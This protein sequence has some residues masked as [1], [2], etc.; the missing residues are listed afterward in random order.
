MLFGVGPV[1]GVATA[2]LDAFFV[3]TVAP[4]NDHVVWDFEADCSSYGGDPDNDCYC[5]TTDPTVLVRDNCPGVS[6]PSQADSDGDGLG[7]ACDNCP[8]AANATQ[9][10]S[11]GDGVGDACDN[12]PAIANPLQE[13]DDGDEFGNVCD[14]CPN[15]RFNDADGDGICGDVD[16]CPNEPNPGQEDL[17]GDGF[18]DACDRGDIYTYAG[19]PESH[20]FC[21]TCGDGGPALSATLSEPM[22]IAFDNAG[23]LYIADSANDRIRMVD[24]SGNVSTIAG[25]GDGNVHATDNGDGGLATQAVLPNPLKIAIDPSSTYLYVSDASNRVRRVSLIAP[26]TIDT[27][28]GTGVSGYSGDGGL[29]KSAKLNNPAGLAVTSDTLYIADYGNLCIRAVDLVTNKKIRTI[30]GNT[31]DAPGGDGGNAL[32]APV[33]FPTDLFLAGS[34]L[35]VSDNADNSNRVRVIDLDTNQIDAFAGAIA[36]GCAPPFGDNGPALTAH[37][38]FPGG[39][40]GDAAG[41]VYIADTDGNRIRKVTT[42]GKIHTIA[43]SDNDGFAGDGGPATA[44]A[45][46]LPAAVAVR[47]DG[48]IYVVDTENGRIR[49]IAYCGNGIVESGEQCDDANLADGDGCSATCRIEAIPPVPQPVAAGGT[50]STPLAAAPTASRPVGTAVT[51]P[52]AQDITIGVSAGPPTLPAGFA[53]FGVTIDINALPTVATTPLE[54]AFTFDVSLVPFAQPDT[55]LGLLKIFRD[56]VPIDDPCVPANEANPDPCVKSQTRIAGNDAEIRILSTHAS[57]W[58]AGLPVCGNGQLDGA[59]ACDDGNRIGGD[60]CS[61]TCT[62]ESCF[63]CSGG[64]AGSCSALPDS[65][66]DGVCDAQD[67]CANPSGDFKAA[68]KPKLSLVK[69]NTD[70]LPG[71]DKLTLQGNFDLPTG[72]TFAGI[73]PLTNGVRVLLRNR[74]GGTELDVTLPGGVY[75]GLGTRGWKTNATRSN[76]QYVDKTT[77]GTLASMYGGINQFQVLD[78]SKKVPHEVMVKVRGQSGTYPVVGNDSPVNATVVLGNASAG[79][80][81]LCGE[82][83][84]A[85]A[86]CNF[87]RKGDALTCK[88]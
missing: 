16:N 34:K 4:L 63:T 28:A 41:N 49:R 48:S 25:N 14:A 26:K 87:N 52:V 61:A 6:N 88:P 67:V 56:G 65:D 64:G 69:I 81:G 23:N 5:D 20:G 18:G 60:G 73:T 17:D 36:T 59:E 77:D 84:F 74:L 13:N 15:D 8:M 75:G 10:D 12:C 29:A 51:A 68:A 79:N 11:D 80:A 7:D 45:L 1:G 32:A 46:S 31:M 39:V 76:W 22:G 57:Q 53:A 9:V 58:A 3:S 24:T 40:T 70:P 33:P 19:G 78:R 30:A 50:A 43:G 55:A 47:P 35:Y 86:M 62:V 82:S 37:M 83:N 44:A 54:F 85:A 38:C 72:Q 27:I 2:Y 71:N 21:E 66:G 42:D